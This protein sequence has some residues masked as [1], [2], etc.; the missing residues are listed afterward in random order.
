MN[1]SFGRPM[2]VESATWVHGL[3]N[4]R[5]PL[6]RYSIRAQLINFH[7]ALRAVIPLLL[8][9]VDRVNLTASSR[10]SRPHRKRISALAPRRERCA[11]YRHSHGVRASVRNCRSNLTAAENEFARDMPYTRSR[12]WRIIFFSVNGQ[13]QTSVSLARSHAKC[14]NYWRAI[15]NLSS[16]CMR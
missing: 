14:E 11:L 5:S 10:S 13:S 8:S 3:G 7:D 6:F 9:I 16:K 15:H 2:T 1:R 12:G 4:F